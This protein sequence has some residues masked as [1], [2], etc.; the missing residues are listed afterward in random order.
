MKSFRWH[1][2]ETGFEY[3]LQQGAS[4]VVLAGSNMLIFTF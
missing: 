1:A 4:E 2:E 3:I